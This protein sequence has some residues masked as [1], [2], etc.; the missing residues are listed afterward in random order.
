MKEFATKE[1]RS[2]A[3]RLYTEHRLKNKTLMGSG[4]K[5]NMKKFLQKHKFR[6][7]LTALIP[8]ACFIPGIFGMILLIIQLSAFATMFWIGWD[9]IF[10]SI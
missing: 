2:E 4:K 6:V 3:L 5:E 1:Q 10:D 7:W 9:N 8:L